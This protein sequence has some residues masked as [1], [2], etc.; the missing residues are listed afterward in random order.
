MAAVCLNE[1]RQLF[2]PEEIGE[3]VTSEESANSNDEISY[4][5]VA[6]TYGIENWGADTSVS[7]VEATLLLTRPKAISTV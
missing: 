6:Q 1:S 4:A 7:I 2:D 5:E 3:P